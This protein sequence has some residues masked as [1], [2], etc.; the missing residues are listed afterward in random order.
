M[1]SSRV[2]KR[3]LQR[4]GLG[5]LHGRAL[6]KSGDS[7]G[8]RIRATPIAEAMLAPVVMEH[9]LRQR[10]LC[11]DGVVATPDVQARRRT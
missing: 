11:G 4:A 5:R 7:C 9:A 2:Q 6:R 10:A 1:R 8:A 3:L